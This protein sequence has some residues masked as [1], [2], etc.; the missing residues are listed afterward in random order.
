VTT[1]GGYHLY[2]HQTVLDPRQHWPCPVLLRSPCE[3][4]FFLEYGRG[5]TPHCVATLKLRTIL[6]GVDAGE[7]F[8]EIRQWIRNS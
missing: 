1:V 2:L 3:S 6:D 8:N 5:G 7:D 4:C